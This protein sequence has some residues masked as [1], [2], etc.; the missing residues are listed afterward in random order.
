[1]NFADVAER[2][3]PAVVNIEATTHSTGTSGRR[4]IHPQS[5]SGFVID[6]NGEILTN[7]HVIQNAERIMVKFSNGRNLQARVLGID[8]DTDIAL[9]K[10]DAHNLPVA[11]LGDSRTLRVGEWVCA[12]GNPLAYEHTVTV[13]VVSYLGRKLFDNSLDDYIQTDAA[14]NF[15]N[16]GGPL[17]NGRGEVVGINSAISQRASNIGFAVPINEARAILPQLKSEGRV[18]RGFMGVALTDVDPDLQRSLRLGSTQGALVQDVTNGSPGQRAGLRTY[19]LIVGIDGTRIASNDEIIRE[20]ARRGPGTIARLDVLRDGRTHT[21]TVRLAERPSRQASSPAED[22]SP[23][24]R[25]SSNTVTPLGL[26][27]RDLDRVTAKRLRLPSGVDGVI[28]TRVDPLSPAY[29]AGIQRDHIFLEI[30]R[31]AV[32]S[33]DAYHR[34]TRAASPGDV[35][36][37]YVYMPG[38]GQYAIRAIRVDAP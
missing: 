6:G 25:P 11:P 1:M 33:A 37:V 29:D 8:P 5:G 10:V 16:S 32:S 17:I 26:G 35:L 15:G 20:V 9:I 2:I 3:N 13:G 22:A 19:D 23:S 38:T 12:I 7:Y 24:V 4:S 31:R 34:L 30:N 14:I 21:L 18:A 27:V 36:A 28:V